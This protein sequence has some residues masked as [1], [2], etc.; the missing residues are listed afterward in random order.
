METQKR[1]LAQKEIRHLKETIEA[2]RESMEKTKADGQQMI[3]QAVS[4][5]NYEIEQLKKTAM[6]L[7]SKLEELKIE[8]Q[9]AVQQAVSKGNNEIIQL[10]KTVAALRDELEMGNAIQNQKTRN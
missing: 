9:E 8:K 4:G 7:R 1:Y 2:M 10:K 3:Q 5:A 6:A